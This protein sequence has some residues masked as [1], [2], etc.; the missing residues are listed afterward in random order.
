MQRCLPTP[1]SVPGHLVLCTL[2]S[3]APPTLIRVNLRH[4][5]LK[6]KCF[7]LSFERPQISDLRHVEFFGFVIP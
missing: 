4:L 1:T 5:R 6:I 7:A 3:K 2:A